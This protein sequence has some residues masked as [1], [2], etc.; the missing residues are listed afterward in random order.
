M[1]VTSGQYSRS[2][3]NPSAWPAQVNGSMT[4]TQQI[5]MDVAINAGLAL[6]S[7]KGILAVRII[8]IISVCVSSDS[9]NQPV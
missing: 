8:W 7:M 4:P 1:T 5:T 6:L 2:H 9:T 3:T